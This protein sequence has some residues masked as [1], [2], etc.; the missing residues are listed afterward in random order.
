M[1]HPAGVADVRAAEAAAMAVAP[2]G[3]LMRRAS[4]GLADIVAR[5]LTA[6]V[7]RPTKASIVILAGSGSNGGDALFAGAV[8]ASQGVNVTAVTTSHSWHE[9]GMAAL[10]TQGGIHVAADEVADEQLAAIGESCSMVIDGIVGIGGVGG[11]RPGAVRALTLITAHDPFVVSVDIPSGV[12]AD[13]GIVSGD[14]MTGEVVT[15]DVTVTFGAL[16]PGLLIAPGKEHAGLV[17]LVDIGITDFLESPEF[18]VL[19]GVDVASW[20]PEPTARSHKYNRGVVGVAAGSPAYVGA[21]LLCTGAARVGGVGM[22]HFLDRGDSVNAA[23]ISRY[24]DVVAS[25]SDPRSLTRIT[26]WVCGSGLDRGV[27]ADAV[28]AVLAVESPVVLDASALAI[29]A[30]DDSLRTRIIERFGSGLTT[31]ITPHSG[32]FEVMFPGLLAKGRLAA[33]VTAAGELHAIVVLKGSGTLIA[34]PDG[35]VFIDTEG[36]AVLSC[37]GS[38]DVLAG[39]IG[40]MV[41]AA[42]ARGE[43]DLAAATAAAVWIHGRAGRIAGARGKPVTALEILTS[44]PDAI[45]HARRGE[46]S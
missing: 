2:S 43:G 5:L 11:L 30:D 27:D 3:D 12:D 35:R 8:L 42:H 9:E 7:S 1:M 14:V 37:A 41:A 28:R 26:G 38:G 19:D 17:E 32:E 39:V 15:A 36:T 20:L 25:G 16:K 6:Q 18:S 4:R 21:A 10:V 33:A 29:V 44:L 22:V 46:S 45:S 23:V 13:S 40:S 31:V 34:T 24:P